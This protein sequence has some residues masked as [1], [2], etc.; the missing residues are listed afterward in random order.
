VLNAGEEAGKADLMARRLRS[1]GYR[2]GQV[3]NSQLDYAE[4]VVLAGP[5]APGPAVP[6]V[7]AG[8]VAGR[9]PLGP[10]VDGPV[11]AVAVN[12]S[13]VVVDAAASVGWLR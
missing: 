5:G 13:A 11:G 10:S 8:T 2:I 3:G 12:G 7:A 1:M 9:G 6:G 4:P